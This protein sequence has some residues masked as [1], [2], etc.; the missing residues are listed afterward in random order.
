[1]FVDFRDSTPPP[2]WQPAPRDPRPRLTRRQQDV[3]GL[4]IAA[5][6][7]LLLVAPIGGA[8]IIQAIAALWR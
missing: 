5:N 7:V 6:L 8:T 4:I 1:M 3:L 2:P